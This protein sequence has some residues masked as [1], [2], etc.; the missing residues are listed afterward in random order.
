MDKK[1]RL[2]LILV[3][4]LNLACKKDIVKIESDYETTL[5][6]PDLSEDHPKYDSYSKILDE[7]IGKGILGTSI[8]I[9]DKDGSWLGAGGYA[10]IVSDIKV[11]K[12]HS[13]F[14]ASISKTFTA[15]A[16]FSYAEVGAL[17]ID[18]PINKWLDASI[19]NRIE[20][21]NSAQ[22]KHLLSHRSGIKDWYTIALEMARYN[23]ESNGWTD[24]DILEYVFDKKADFKLDERYGY[25]N[26][27]YVLLGMILEKVSGQSL[28]EVYQV[29]LFDPLGLKSASYHTQADFFKNH[30]V[31]GYGDLYGSGQYSESKFLYKD[32][33][34]T[35]D[36]GIS[37]NAQD[38]GTFFRALMHGEILNLNTL[39]QMQNWFDLPDN[40]VQTK[41][42]YGLE[43]FENKKGIAYGH[44]G[45]VDGFSSMSYYYPKDDVNVV[46]LFNYSTS[47]DKDYELLVNFMDAMDEAIFD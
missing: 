11:Q 10:D 15:T 17:S 19:C 34:G 39:S 38:L 21:G 25:S 44:T 40:S 46:F 47:T 16:I 33:M 22:I 1:I 4:C 36:G 5:S 6:F 23:V 8:M 43:Y 14:I 32:E 27:N 26:T 30:A 41:N 7:Y 18:D 28:E 45:G 2:G 37:I 31:K 3:L 20:N 35:G 9:T 12:G 42:G 13:F 29:R 24:D